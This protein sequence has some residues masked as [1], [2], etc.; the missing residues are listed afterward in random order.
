MT[1]MVATG[2]RDIRDARRLADLEAVIKGG[3]QSFVEVGEALLEIRDS[4]LYRVGFGTF[5]E[6]TRKRWGFTRQ[7]GMQLMDAAEVVRALP[8]MT[9]TVVNEAQARALAPVLA[10]RGPEAA[11]AVL[12]DASEATNGH[13]TA[14]AI[15]AAARPRLDPT[16]YAYGASATVSPEVITSE[17][18][19]I[20]D[21]LWDALMATI[22]AISGLAGHDAASVAATVPERRRAAT[23]KRLRKLGTYLGRI[24]WTLEGTEEPRD[25]ARSDSEAEAHGDEG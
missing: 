22:D 25:D 12:T 4:K 6:Y 23:A 18:P 7:R 19:S 5:E 24:A 15:T 8:E 1:A 13:V 14:A 21:A 2:P 17:G 16:S 10:E 11:A 20:D 9:T 3:L